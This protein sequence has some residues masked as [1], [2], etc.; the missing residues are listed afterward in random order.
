MPMLADADMCIRSSG[1]LLEELL[2]IQDLN[3]GR[4]PEVGWGHPGA[5]SPDD[6]FRGRHF[7]SLYGSI[8]WV[9]FA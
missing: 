8:G 1:G 5:Q 7:E 3:C 4:W 9:H 6:L 2:L